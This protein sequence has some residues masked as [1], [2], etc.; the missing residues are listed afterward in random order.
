MERKNRFKEIFPVVMIFIT[1]NTFILTAKNMLARWHADQEVLLY[2]N[3][4][5][6]LITILSFFI[7][8]S[9][10]SNKNPHAFVRSVYGSI[11]LKLFLCLILAFAY[12]AIYRSGLNKPALFVCMGFYL[13]YTAFEVAALMKLLKGRTNG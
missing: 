9:G 6:F 12:I 2:G 13:L 5:I 11:M 1:L 4:A 8:R 10:L 3:I 7:A